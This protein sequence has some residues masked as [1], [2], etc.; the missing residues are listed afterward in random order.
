MTDAAEYSRSVRYSPEDEGWMATCDEL[1]TIS[2]FGDS[3]E[4]ALRELEAVLEEA[5]SVYRENGWPLP[6]PIHAAPPDLPS[7]EFRLRLPKTLHAQLGARAEREGVS[8][9]ALVTYLLA[10]GLARTARMQQRLD[11]RG[12]EVP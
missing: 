3:R 12:E 7:G 8:Q 2:A 11:L 5:F 1:P 6:T 10:E 4:E 9:N